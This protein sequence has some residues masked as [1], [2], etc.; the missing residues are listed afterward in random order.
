MAKKKDVSG[1]RTVRTYAYLDHAAYWALEKA[2]TEQEGSFF[3]SMFA[4]LGAVHAVE[5]YLNHLGRPLFPDWDKPGLRTPREKFTAL[6]TRYGLEPERYKKDYAA[7]LI[8]LDV[9]DDLVH[10]RTEWLAG[11][12]SSQRAE[13]RTMDVL[14]TNWEKRGNPR[15]ARKVF[16]ACEGLMDALAKGSGDKAKPYNR[17]GFAYAERKRR[18][19]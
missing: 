7:Y 1:E 12:W 11:E 17:F 8:G 13:N 10:G 5:A 14:K 19:R 18:A 4:I 9:R 15:E 6:R 3:S 2:E 16:E